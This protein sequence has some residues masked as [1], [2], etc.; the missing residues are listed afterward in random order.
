MGLNSPAE[1]RSKI[2]KKAPFGNPNAFKS[3]FPDVQRCVYVNDLLTKTYANKGPRGDY[4]FTVVEACEQF[5]K[6]VRETLD[7]ERVQ[8]YILCMD[9]EE[10]M[11]PDKTL[12]RKRRAQKRKGTANDVHPYPEGAVLTGEGIRIKGRLSPTFHMTR[13][14]RAR[15]LRPSFWRLLLQYIIRQH[16]HRPTGTQ[17]VFDHFMDGA[18]LIDH[19]GVHNVP[20]SRHLYGEADMGMPYWLNRYG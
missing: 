19:N 1:L 5:Y 3:T 14:M 12:E 6:Q 2:F 11:N 9:Q 16:R 20:N 4:T 17:V 7:A 8:V 13:L 15:S 18:K 10:Y